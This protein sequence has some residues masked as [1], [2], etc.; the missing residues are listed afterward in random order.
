MSQINP[1]LIMR[2][3]SKIL[4]LLTFIVVIGCTVTKTICPCE[5]PAILK[6]GMSEIEINAQIFLIDSTS[7]KGM[8]VNIWLTTTDHTSFPINLE[9]DYYYLRSSNLVR[10]AIEGKFT[11]INTD[12]ANG[13]MELEIKNFPT[14]NSGEL[15]DVAVHLIDSRGKKYFIKRDSL[16]I[17]TSNTK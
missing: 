11:S 9:T 10:A 5:A 12:F 17:Q 7:S 4:G 1:F 2:Y 14:W 6:I 15:I 16:P 8:K 13:I 3:S